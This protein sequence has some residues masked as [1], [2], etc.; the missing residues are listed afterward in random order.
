MNQFFGL[1]IFYLLSR[2]LNKATFGEMQWTL[3]V[4]L[5]C[6][7][8]LS[9]GVDQIIV[10]KVAAGE[11]SGETFSLYF[12]HVLFSGL[13]F[14]SV[15]TISN[16]LFLHFYSQHS[17]L[18][19]LA[20]GKLLFFFS[21]PFKQIATGFEK[22]N[23]LMYMSVISNILKGVL[24]ICFA[25]FG[26]LTIR[27]A[28]LAFVVADGCEFLI[29]LLIYKYF[30][31]TGIRFRFKRNEYFGLIRESLPQAGV[32]FFSSALA[33]ADWIL[34][35]LFL[36]AT[37]LAEYGF[38]YKVF[39]LSTL[40]LL[41]IAPLL[42]PLFSRQ[43]REGKKVHCEEKNLLLLR[44]ELIVAALSALLLNIC[45]VPFIDPLTG[46]RYGSINSN[47]IFI[48]SLSIPLLYLNNFLW[49]LHFAQQRLKMIL[50]IF[51][52][53][54]FINLAA[55]CLL[56]PLFKNEGAAISF[57]LSIFI[58]TALYSAK[59]DERMNTG[60]QSLIACSV[61]AFFC[62]AIAKALFS[63]VWI[64]LSASFSL[65]ILL[66]FITLQLTQN[67]WRRLRNILLWQRGN[68]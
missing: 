11:T 9:F 60:W 27:N 59:L 22:F 64:V 3:A 55:N 29:S 39:E 33:R 51:A 25:F 7:S 35:G 66:L 54:F 46:G 65:Y 16:F 28:I 21:T 62:G 40:P 44:I 47:T 18:L 53:T 68:H 42:L 31:K 67:D 10:R 36:S 57:V 32:A 6:F 30:F 17:L 58:Q 4:C 41:V 63:S 8:I 34:I 5:T 15:L 61:A 1:V 24:L 23:L 13:F 50:K 2:F 26:A 56:I 20:A 12:F 19:M 48:L 14:Y 43:I 37:K 45:W 49:S 52:I 38:A